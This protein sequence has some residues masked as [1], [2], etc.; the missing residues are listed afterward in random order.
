MTSDTSVPPHA[1][2]FLKL[3]GTHGGRRPG[4]GAPVGNTNALRT[5]RFSTRYSG[6]YLIIATLNQ[7]HPQQMAALRAGKTRD[8]L[9]YF[10]AAARDVF[11]GCPE[12]A[13]Q[14]VGHLSAHLAAAEVNGRQLV[15]LQRPVLRFLLKLPPRHRFENALTL[16]LYVAQHSP[17][18]ALKAANGLFDRFAT[19]LDF[20]YRQPTADP[21]NPQ[22]NNHSIK[23]DELRASTHEL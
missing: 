16:L 19:A 3:K 14:I 13:D 21:E 11:E 10:L 22:S 23:S 15:P 5:G 9:A 4:A 18:V 1:N 20:I 8:H 12:L 17:A 6:A 7:L 2:P